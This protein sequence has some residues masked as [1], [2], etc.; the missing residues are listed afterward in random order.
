MVP[1]PESRAVAETDS[2]LGSADSHPASRSPSRGPRLA[3]VAVAAF[4][5]LAVAVAATGS[6]GGV[7]SASLASLGLARA[8]GHP[9]RHRP[10]PWDSALY[11]HPYREEEAAD[12]DRD[13]D[14]DRDDEG[15]RVVGAGARGRERSALGATPS[16]TATPA[17][18]PGKGA[19]FSVEQ[20]G[21]VP[22]WATAE[23]ARELARWSDARELPVADAAALGKSHPRASAGVGDSGQRST[24]RQ[25]TRVDPEETSTKRGKREGVQT[26]APRKLGRL[27]AARGGLPAAE[28]VD[29][30]RPGGPTGAEL[31]CRSFRGDARACQVYTAPGQTCWHKTV[32]NEY[33]D[34]HSASDGGVGPVS[35]RVDP[36]ATVEWT[37]RFYD[38]MSGDP[39][40]TRVAEAPYRL[41]LPSLGA[42]GEIDLGGAPRKSFASKPGTAYFYSFVHVPKAGGTYFKSLLHRSES[43]RNEKLGGPD[44]RWDES[45]TKDWTTYPLVDMTEQSYANVMWRYVHR[46]PAKMF[47][48]D[49]MRASYEAGYRAVSKGAL[50]MGACDHIDAPC[51]YL[52][53]L[54]DPVERYMSHYSYLC[55]EGS[56]HM[57]GWKEAWKAR[58]AKYAERGCPAD[59]VQFFDQVGGFVQLFA[60]GANP[61]TRCAVEAAKRNLGSGCMRYLLLEKLDDGLARMRATL[62]D[63]PDIGAADSEFSEARR[64]GSNDR[65]TPTT[66]K[67]LEKYLGDERMMR[68]LR[69]LL[70]NEIDVY[71]WAVEN[72]ERQWSGDL[73]TC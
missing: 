6:S 38:C 59:P 35:M 69:S 67:R 18:E 31:L 8:G 4:A 9:R 10:A 26:R 47:G 13:V 72:Y 44:P 65:L 34:P 39:E 24:N 71:D 58:S 45:V 43:R 48:G 30:N 29:P 51:A 19:T 56:E 49:G 5:L 33:I 2:L 64:N 3:V 68:T 73:L 22:K 63:F 16:A 37:G 1:R 50:S 15:P 41:P 14:A 27:E 23:G 17:R 53:V 7:V 66:R 54:R 11:G 62:P 28:C 42:G 12:A 70:A 52:T 61:N 55:L 25:R 36:E 57:T 21:G 46:H 60:P 40:Y 20:P 32:G